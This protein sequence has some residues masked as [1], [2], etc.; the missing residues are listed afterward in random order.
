MFANTQMMGMDMAFPDVCLTPAP[1]SPSPIPIPYPNMGMGPT[2]NPGTAS[3]K[4]L[5]NMMPA[6]NLRTQIPMTQGDNAGVSMGVASGRVMGPSRHLTGA[7][8][9]LFEGMPASR[10][11]SASIQNGTNAPGMR[12]A[13]SQTTVLLLAP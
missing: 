11:T 9:V 7:F 3:R 13:P 8:T 1:P 2:A 4:I 10:M 12:L 6:H 5:I